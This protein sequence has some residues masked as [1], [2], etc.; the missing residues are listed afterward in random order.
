MIKENKVSLWL[1]YFEKENEFRDYM[2]VEYDEDGN[3]TP[4]KF[5]EE[6][7]I[8]KYD[9]DATEI[10]WISDMCADVDTLLEGFSNDFEIIPQF[11]ELLLNKNIMQYNSI[12]LFYNFEYQGTYLTS[13]LEY[14]GCVNVNL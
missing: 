13:K 4:S 3:I 7:S 5:Q 9:L 1:G 6:F 12:I 11:K 2:D 14:I 10:D 8:E